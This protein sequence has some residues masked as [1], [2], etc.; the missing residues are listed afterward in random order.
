MN[1]PTSSIELLPASGAPQ[2][3]M[4][5]LHGVGANAQNLLPLA[6]VLRQQ[7]PQAA[8]LLLQGYEPF[9]RHAARRLG[10]AV[11]FGARRD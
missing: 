10:A 6:Q 5:L 4:V 11:V 1:T 7:F 2:Q 9:G 8:V 3:L